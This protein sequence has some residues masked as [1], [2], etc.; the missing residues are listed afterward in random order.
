MQCLKLQQEWELRLNFFYR[1]RVKCMSP[2]TKYIGSIISIVQFFP[3]WNIDKVKCNRKKIFTSYFLSC[4]QL[5]TFRRLSLGE[6]PQ[7]ESAS[8]LLNSKGKEY[9]I[10]PVNQRKLLE[11]LCSKQKGMRFCILVTLVFAFSLKPCKGPKLP[12]PSCWT[13]FLP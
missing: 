12:T 2:K 4:V 11:L 13:C 5:H 9:F 3:K 8:L 7:R 10:R 6:W 1:C